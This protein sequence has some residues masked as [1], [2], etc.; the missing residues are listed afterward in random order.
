MIAKKRKTFVIMVILGL[1][2]VVSI[3][4]VA[5]TSAETKTNNTQNQN[6]VDDGQ[7][8]ENGTIGASKV[9]ETKTYNAQ[10][11]NVISDGQKTE[12]ETA[13]TPN[14]TTVKAI[15][16]E[17][18]NGK[19]V[20]DFFLLNVGTSYDFITEAFKNNFFVILDKPIV[21]NSSEVTMALDYYILTPEHSRIIFKVSGV[22][23]DKIES[24]VNE[25]PDYSKLKND[26]TFG[27]NFPFIISKLILK[28]GDGKLLYD[29]TQAHDDSG[30][31]KYQPNIYL[32]SNL[33]KKSN[34][35]F[36]EIALEEY[37]GVYL[38][39]PDMLTIEIDGLTFGSSSPIDGQWKFE[40]PVDDMF[41]NTETL[42]YETISPEYCDKNGIYVDNF[43]STVTS[44]KMELTI[45]NSKNSVQQPARDNDIFLFEDPITHSCKIPYEQK[46]FVEVDGE[47]LFE[48][49]ESSNG[50][51]DTMT[52]YIGE[53]Y[54]PQ[55]TDK[56]TKYFLYLPTLYFANA[57][58]VTVRLL[59]E[60]RKPL[61]VN[62]HLNKNSS[63][64]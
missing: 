8:T 57:E 23:E 52:K 11:E 43:C 25:N 29:S 49:A 60:N 20:K 16:N 28:D 2:L 21:A 33:Y 39:I 13:A 15:P 50:V 32:S 56:G 53:Y 38:R 58:N 18:T 31:P 36:L 48:T 24:K 35:V 51:F 46:L 34:G 6:T 22:P 59:D 14:A 10:N 44:T 64:T 4:A 40:L 42:R 62:L 63:D 7:K 55:Q 9:A 47:Q 26:Y 1:I 45:D 19:I 30:Q 27:S 41:K 3:G 54:W 37:D 61:E 17:L 5:F 12:N